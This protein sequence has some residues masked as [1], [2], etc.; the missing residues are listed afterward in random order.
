[1]ERKW[2]ARPY[3]DGDERGIL[4]LWKAV[5]PEREYNQEKWLRWWNWKFKGN[6]AGDSLV[7]VADHDGKIVGQVSIIPVRMKVGNEIVTAGLVGDTMTHPEYRRQR[8]SMAIHNGVYAQA[9]GSGISFIFGFPNKVNRLVGVNVGDFPVARM[10][11]LARVLSWGSALRMRTRSKLLLKLGSIGG[12]L[13][14]GVFCRARRMPAVEGLSVCQIPFFDESINQ[15][16]DR[17]SSQYHITTVRTKDYLNWRYVTVPDVSY[18]IYIAEKDGRIDGYLVLGCEQRTE[19]KLG[20][21]LDVVARSGWTAQCLVAR[22]VE[23]CYRE[24]AGLVY[25]SVAANKTYVKAFRRDGFISVPFIKDS[26]FGRLI[27]PVIP[28]DFLEDS[29]NWFIQS[30]DAV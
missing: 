22:A 24:K 9:E 25:C 11:V 19:V 29:K 4:E 8:I 16:W 17:V 7:C 20:V 27:S 30:G 12:N 18:S 15:L 13:F 3:R 28:R 5:Y 2:K 21:I 10:Q 14:S 1:M 6:P 26:L 23:Q